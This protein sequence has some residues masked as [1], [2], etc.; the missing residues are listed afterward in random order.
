MVAARQCDRPRIQSQW[1][2]GGWSECGAACPYLELLPPEFGEFIILT[3]VWQWVMSSGIIHC[4]AE[5]VDP[6]ISKQRSTSSSRV[7]QVLYEQLD[8]KD[9]GIL[10]V[11]TSV[12]TTQHHSTWSRRLECRA[13]SLR[14]PQIPEGSHVWHKCF[15]NNNRPHLTLFW[16]HY[17][18]SC[19][20]IFSV[21][22]KVTCNK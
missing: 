11:P 8:P 12:S 20:W 5:P 10:F 18:T 19:V 7:K 21:V 4:V 17:Y 2:D 9:E 13:A 16:S 14:F 3:G 15:G 6:D 1:Q 22:G